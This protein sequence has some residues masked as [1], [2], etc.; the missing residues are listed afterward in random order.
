ML[1]EYLKL[2][3]FRFSRSIYRTQMS[4]LLLFDAK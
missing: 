1:E 3:H 4:S 2:G